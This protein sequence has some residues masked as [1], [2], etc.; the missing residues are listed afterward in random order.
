MATM[1][2][3]SR[4]Y[5]IEQKTLMLPDGTM[6][7]YIGRRFVPQPNRFATIGEHVVAQGERPDTVAAQVLGDPEQF[8]RLCDSN[9]VLQ[10]EELTHEP[11]ERIRITLPEGIPA[12]RNA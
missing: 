1:A 6:I 12:P 11:G 8:W 3:I 10:P 5:N 4:Y 7:A 2:M 9:A